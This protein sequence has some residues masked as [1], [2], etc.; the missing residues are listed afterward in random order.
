MRSFTQHDILQMEKAYRTPLINGLSG[1]R[2]AVLVGTADAQGVP[3]LAVFFSTIH[4]GANPPLMGL[5]L[6]PPAARQH[7]REH[8][9]AT[10]SFTINAVTQEMHAAAHRASLRSPAE[11]DEFV[12][13]GFT[14]HHWPGHHAPAVAESP[15]RIGLTLVEHH[16]VAANA[17]TLVIGAIEHVDVA[18]ELLDADGHLRPDRADVVCCGD[19]ETYYAPRFINRL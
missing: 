4:M 1:F 9:F 18:D 11:E 17:T 12:T 2:S 6:R 7:T 15:I 3:N 14:P 19:L 10:G 16:D 13:C 5:L 8:L